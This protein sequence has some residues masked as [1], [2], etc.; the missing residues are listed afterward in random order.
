MK[1]EGNYTEKAELLKAL[2]HPT[3]LCIVHGL[4]DSE[5]NVNKITGCMEM[6]QSTISQQLAIL[7][8]KGII[9][10]RRKGTEIC[11]SVINKKAREIVTLLMND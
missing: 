2:A 11:Y 9:E 1:I 6:P 8:S 7:R 5:C 3:R 10:G 4:M